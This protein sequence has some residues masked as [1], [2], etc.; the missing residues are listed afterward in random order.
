MLPIDPIGLGGAGGPDRVLVVQRV[1]EAMQQPM[2]AAEALPS[3]LQPM[4]QAAP[5]SMQPA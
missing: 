5:A 2:A 3:A 1:M 4:Q